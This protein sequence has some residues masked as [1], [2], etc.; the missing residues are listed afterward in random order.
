MRRAPSLPA[1]VDGLGALAFAGERT[2]PGRIRLMHRGAIA[3]LE[4]N[5]GYGYIVRPW[6][7]AK[8]ILFSAS[9]LDGW[10][11]DQLRVGQAVEF[12]LAPDPRGVRA[13]QVRVV[14]D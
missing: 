5:R 1:A 2:R 8:E 7:G 6:I 9:A 13:V 10:S 11:F 3:R 12:D 4:S 14:E